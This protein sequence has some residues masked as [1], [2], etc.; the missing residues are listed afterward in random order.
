[1][2]LVE[3]D[4]ARRLAPGLERDGDVEGLLAARG[5][6][7]PESVSSAG[8]GEKASR[9]RRVRPSSPS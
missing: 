1:M 7:Q 5:Q 9:V 3:A 8:L 4:D 6:V 2:G